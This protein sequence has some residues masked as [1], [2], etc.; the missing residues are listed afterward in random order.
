MNNTTGW[1]EL[2]VVIFISLCGLIVSCLF[3][4][5]GLE[6]YHT[7]KYNALLTQYEKVTQSK[8]YKAIQKCST[9]NM[10]KADCITWEL[11]NG[12]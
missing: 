4:I 5:K 6:E 1:K 9:E 10:W 12:E 3:M 8:E 2:G 11:N 7:K